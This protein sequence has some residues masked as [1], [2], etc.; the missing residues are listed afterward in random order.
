M[1]FDLKSCR[2]RL[3]NLPRF[4]K[5]ESPFILDNVMRLILVAIVGSLIPF[6]AYGQRYSIKLDAHEKAGQSYHLIAWSTEKTTVDLRA[7]AQ[8]L[9]QSEDLL[10]AEISADVTILEASAAGWATR[11]R[12]KVLSSKVTRSGT[13]SPILP[14]GT[15]V[16]ASIQNGETLYEVDQTLVDEKTA[17]ALRVLIGLHVTS[18]ANDD[19]FGTPT[20]KKIGERWPA[21]VDA[22]K[23]LLKEIGDQSSNPEITGSSTLEKVENNHIFLRASVRVRNVLLPGQLTTE[24]GEIETELW[25]RFPIRQSDTTVES[26]DRIHLTRIASGINADGK[27]VTLQVVYERTSRYETRPL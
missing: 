27:K 12:F 8:V 25:G 26:N 22:M 21:G 5:C 9:Q 11:K 13:S 3:A 17:R 23:K 19:M 4:R 20:P 7:A 2:H 14:D 16:M 15:Q 6:S 10:A 1:S 18:V 24:G